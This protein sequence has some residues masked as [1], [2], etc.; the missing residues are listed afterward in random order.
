MQTC[1]P[2]ERYDV[3]IYDGIVEHILP[4]YVNDSA[5]TLLVA[6]H[7]P[8]GVPHITAARLRSNGVGQRV[9]A[10]GLSP[11]GTL[12]SSRKFGFDAQALDVSV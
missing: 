10:F 3:A 5:R 11:P 12:W 6:G 9:R 2:R 7:S 1:S 8:G 4:Q